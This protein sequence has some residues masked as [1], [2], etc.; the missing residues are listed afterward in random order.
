LTIL[1]AAGLIGFSVSASS[2]EPSAS[3]TDGR[4][5]A[6]TGSCAQ[7]KCEWFGDG[8]W[9]EK[10]YALV[11]SENSREASRHE[12]KLAGGERNDASASHRP[13]AVWISF[14]IGGY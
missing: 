8:C 1:I 3:V 6:G 7:T 11:V 5:A 14:H 13:P 10:I 4:C 9:N 2:A 12:T